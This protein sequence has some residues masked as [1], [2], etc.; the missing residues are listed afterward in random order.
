MPD[1]RDLKHTY[2]KTYALMH[3][4]AETTPHEH[5]PASCDAVHVHANDPCAVDDCRQPL[6][7]REAC[8][9]VIE[10]KHE[11][12]GERWVCWRHVRP[13]KG[14]LRLTDA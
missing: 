3:P 7:A 12:P 11:G 8:Y 1:L 10:L 9:A 14:P 2:T 4:W 6:K 13:D 5:D